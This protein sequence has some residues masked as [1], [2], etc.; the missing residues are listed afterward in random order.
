META[1]QK[2]KAEMSEPDFEV[3]ENLPTD[4]VTSNGTYAPGMAPNLKTQDEADPDVPP[5]LSGFVCLHN[6]VV[7]WPKQPSQYKGKIK[8]PLGVTLDE[9]KSDEG[10]VLAPG[11]DCAH[12]KVGDEVHYWKH[13]GSW[14]MLD[15][16][17]VRV[18]KETEIYMVK[19]RASGE[20]EPN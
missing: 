3:Y 18:L 13:A 6:W 14:Q 8:L 12:A 10:L 20:A 2:A 16:K 19:R 5:D 17:E 9:K 11:N 4:K 15:G 1:A 7:I